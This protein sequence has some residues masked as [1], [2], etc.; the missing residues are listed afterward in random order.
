MRLF[1]QLGEQ[2]EGMGTQSE[3]REDVSVGIAPVVLR[4][5][6]CS[7]GCEKCPA[8]LVSPELLAED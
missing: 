4:L 1:P 6:W 8:V 3:E 7:D 5:P 2:L